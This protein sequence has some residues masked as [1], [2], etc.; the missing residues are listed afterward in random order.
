M[1]ILGDMA[2]THQRT[3]ANRCVGDILTVECDSTGKNTFQSGN[4]VDQFALSVALDACDADDLAGADLEGNVVYGIALTAF[5]RHTQILYL[6]HHVRGLSRLFLYSE[7]HVPSHHHTGQLGT[8]TILH[9]HRAHILALT[10]NGTAVSHCHD[11]IQLMGDK[12]N[13]FSFCGQI[14]HNLQ[15]LLDL[16]GGQHRCGLIEDQYLVIPVQHLQNLCT[17]LHTDGYILDDG[18]RVYAQ[19]VALGQCHNLLTGLIPL[20]H[21]AL[22]VLHAQD[23]IIQ[24]G[25]AFHHFEVLMHHTDTEV[26]R[27]VGGIDLNHLAVFL[28]DT[29]LC[30]I[31]TEQHAHQSGFSGAVLAQQSMDLPMLQLDRHV[32]V[33]N[34]AGKTFGYVHHFNGV[35]CGIQ[36]NSPFRYIRI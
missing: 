29:L 18:I 11:L 35:R 30:L 31:H 5:R 7:F 10:Q 8:V 4:T 13:G 20:E 28:D 19:S 24:N 9:V 27:I 32:I 6:Q 23:D 36:S 22:C 2:H 15:K 33:G 25:E 14:P 34:D 1:P 12:Q 16:L 3:L 26:I 21:T 17:L